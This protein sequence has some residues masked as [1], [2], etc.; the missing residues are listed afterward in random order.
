MTDHIVLER[1]ARAEMERLAGNVAYWAEVR[2][3]ALWTLKQELGTWKRVA[4]AT[5]QTVPAITKAAYKRPQEGP[6]S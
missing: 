3:T 2:R 1:T 4:D 6:T 5:G